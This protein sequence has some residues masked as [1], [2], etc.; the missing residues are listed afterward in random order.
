MKAAPLTGHDVDVGYS[1]GRQRGGLGVGVQVGSEQSFTTRR[2]AQAIDADTVETSPL[3]LVGTAPYHQRHVARR[4][5]SQ[6]ETLQSNT[7][8]AQY[9]QYQLAPAHLQR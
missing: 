1:V 7:E 9:Q 5:F 3:H 6:H 2:A 8:P 4:P